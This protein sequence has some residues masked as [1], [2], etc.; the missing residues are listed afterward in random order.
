MTE[1]WPQMRLDVEGNMEVIE[2]PFRI[3]IPFFWLTEGGNVPTQARE[4]VNIE[5]NTIVFKPTVGDP[6]PYKVTD[7]DFEH[8][9]FFAERVI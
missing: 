3:A 5:Q 7:F 2:A 8:R 4:F 6:I 1:D 9:R